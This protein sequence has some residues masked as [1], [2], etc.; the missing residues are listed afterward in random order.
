MSYTVTG[1]HP[2]GYLEAEHIY[3]LKEENEFW[4]CTGENNDP[5]KIKLKNRVLAK[6][7]EFKRKWNRGLIK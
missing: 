2:E 5:E 6:R 4:A 1:K 3:C 7:E